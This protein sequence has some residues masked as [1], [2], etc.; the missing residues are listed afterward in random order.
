MKLSKIQQLIPI[1]Q[2]L[3]ES[4]NVFTNLE[5]LERKAEAWFEKLQGYDS[6][7][8]KNYIREWDGIKMPTAIDIL[9]KCREI[10]KSEEDVSHVMSSELMCE[11]HKF[12]IANDECEISKSQCKNNYP[13]KNKSDFVRI[14]VN[15]GNVTVCYWHE[16]I[17][18]S[19][20]MDDKRSKDF[21][22]GVISFISNKYGSIYF[23]VNSL[24]KKL[25]KKI[26]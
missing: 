16:Q 11:Y 20:F 1:L 12:T 6:D 5:S 21:V 10:N 4:Y 24:T 15:G 17:M 22:D 3:M 18:R 25:I 9:R 13:E 2:N 7:S 23:N 26:N 14:I 8:I 19:K